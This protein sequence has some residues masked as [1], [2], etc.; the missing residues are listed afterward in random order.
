MSYHWKYQELQKGEAAEYCKGENG[1]LD[2]EKFLKWWFM[3]IHEL[4][5]KN[6][7]PPPQEGQ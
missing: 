5:H 7:P 6:D 2:K 1:T 3:D 4:F